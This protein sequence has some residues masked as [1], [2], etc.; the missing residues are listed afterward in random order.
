MF[1]AVAAF[2]KYDMNYIHFNK[3][4]Y[5]DSCNNLLI[6]TMYTVLIILSCQ[7]D[8]FQHTSI[9]FRNRLYFSQNNLYYSEFD[10]KE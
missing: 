4:S 6:I 9:L 2:V 8:I 5:S 1:N 3:N 10:V 7:S